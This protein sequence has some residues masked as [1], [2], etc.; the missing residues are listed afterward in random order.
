KE[1]ID[2]SCACLACSNNVTM[3]QLN[4]F[5]TIKNP[6]AFIYST[7]HNIQFFSNLMENIRNAIK[8]NKFGELKERYFKYF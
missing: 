4:N 7:A 1:V 3:E 6:N 2:K 5:F 8:S